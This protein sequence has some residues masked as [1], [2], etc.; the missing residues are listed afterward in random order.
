M[1]RF[2]FTLAIALI[3]VFSVSNAKADTK[4]YGNISAGYAYNE[5]DEY[6]LD[7]VSYKFGI[8]YELS[9]RWMLEA[10]YQHLGELNAGDSLLEEG[11]SEGNQSAEFSA[12]S[13]SA[14][15]K[16]R[17]TY[18]ELFYRLGVARVD[19]NLRVRNAACPTS[20]CDF[21]ES[22]MAGVVGVGFDFF[23]YENAM[24]RF[25]V[26]HLQGEEDFTTNAAYI[27]VRLNF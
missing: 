2:L 25:E 12:I 23:A 4:F 7:K 24:L 13:I 20:I 14:L 5:L 22:L 15:G 17:G 16:A 9:S 6:E 26:E 21:S 3:A 11:N 27:G 10:N 1:N 18:G 8:G 19:A